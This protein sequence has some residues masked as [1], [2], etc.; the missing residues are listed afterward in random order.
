V[1]KQSPASKQTINQIHQ[2]SKPTI[3]QYCKPSIE[4]MIEAKR[5]DTKQSKAKPSEAKQEHLQGGPCGT[6]F[7]G[8]ADCATTTFQG[9][10]CKR[11]KS[12]EGQAERFRFA[13]DN[14]WNYLGWQ[15]LQLDLFGHKKGNPG[16][17]VKN[18]ASWKP[19]ELDQMNV[20]SS[21]NRTPHTTMIS[22]WGDGSPGTAC[23]L[24]ADNG[25]T[26]S[27]LKRLTEPNTKRIY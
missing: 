13:K 9:P 14:Q 6:S 5:S 11:R 20:L 16:V 27:A 7:R 18:K 23:C 22:A 1:A 19:V 26:D 21:A 12:A 15:A 10:W 25:T 2:S 4:Q 8:V 24:F 3:E 17:I